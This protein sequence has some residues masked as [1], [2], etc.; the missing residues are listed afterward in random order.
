MSAWAESGLYHFDPYSDKRTESVIPLM[1]QLQKMRFAKLALK[2]TRSG[3]AAFNRV[4]G[5][6]TK[7]GLAT[8]PLID[9]GVPCFAWTK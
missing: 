4:F 3:E 9:T 7:A 6:P 1:N 8:V 2:D 5:G